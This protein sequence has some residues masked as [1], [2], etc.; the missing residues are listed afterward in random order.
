MTKGTLQMW[1]SYWS[2]DVKIILDYPGG[3]NI[4]M[5]SFKSEALALE[6]E[7]EMWRERLRETQRCFAASFEE[8][9]RDQE[10][11]KT[12]LG[13]GKGKEMDFPLA[14]PGR[15]AALLTPWFWPS[16]L[17]LDFWPLGLYDNKLALFHANFVVICNSS[18]RKITDTRAK[19]WPS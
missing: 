11:R 9:G 8:G 17:H 2:W 10:P 16:E 12:A 4:I 14:L 13:V 15:N 6:S 19:W 3:P 18:N 5:S 7:K 1:L